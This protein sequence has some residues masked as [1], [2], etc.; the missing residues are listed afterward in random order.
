M[1]IVYYVYQFSRFRI[2]RIMKFSRIIQM[3]VLIRYVSQEI[4]QYVLI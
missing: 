2:I 1:R 3:A 4:P